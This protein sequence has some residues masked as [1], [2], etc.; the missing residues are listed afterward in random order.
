MFNIFFSKIS[1]SITFAC[2]F[3]LVLIGAYTLTNNGGDAGDGYFKAAI[4]L[5]GFG[6]LQTVIFLKRKK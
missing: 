3:T 5:S 2:A 4:G 1:I 6:I